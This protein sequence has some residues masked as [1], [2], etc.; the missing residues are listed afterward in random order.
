[1]TVKQ[2][3]I[4]STVLSPA[5]GVW[6]RSQVEQVKELQVKI[7]GGDRQIIGGYIPHISI[8]ADHAVY[9][10]LHLSKINLSAEN[11]RINLSQV[12]KGKPLRLLEPI[13]VTGQMLLEEADLKASLA[14]PL[15]STALTE[16]LGTLLTSAGIN[17][18]NEFFKDKPINWQQVTLEDNQL[19]IAGVLANK[20]DNLT[21]VAIRTGIQLASNHV[22][23]LAPLQIDTPIESASR[24]L[25]SFELD[26]GSEVNIEELKIMPG[27]L[28]CRGAINV[29]P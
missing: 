13:P 5:C 23:R 10:G 8:L 11:I 14:S 15:L 25:D 9:Q 7:T 19:T 3:R 12:I 29:I 1:M 26:L 18:P 24:S 4:I 21:P 27:Q 6:L 16:L 2:S 20:S 22:L 28:V 17:Q